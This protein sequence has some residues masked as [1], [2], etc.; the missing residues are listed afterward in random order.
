MASPVI[1]GMII[2]KRM[3]TLTHYEGT[4]MTQDK[5]LLWA[6]VW[7]WMNICLSKV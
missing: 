5:L 7:A 3:L 1:G 4:E 2:L 6:V